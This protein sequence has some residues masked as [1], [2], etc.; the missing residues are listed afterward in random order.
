MICLCNT[1]FQQDF[2]FFISRI[3]VDL[4]KEMVY[5]YSVWK[6][7]RKGVICG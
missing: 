7:L 6:S 3:V 2:L 5:I 4:G 1:F